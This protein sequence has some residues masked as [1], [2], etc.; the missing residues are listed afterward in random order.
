VT[1]L[2]REEL[3]LKIQDL[4]EENAELAE[5]LDRIKELSSDAVSDPDEDIE[6]EE[7][8]EDERIEDE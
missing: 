1:T 6:A 4:E 3:L 2:T 5:T 7:D 8:E